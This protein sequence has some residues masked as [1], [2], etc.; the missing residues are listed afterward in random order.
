MNKS[1]KEL[2]DYLKN[3][4]LVEHIT[5][6]DLVSPEISEK[7]VQNYHRSKMFINIIPTNIELI[8]HHIDNVTES[9]E[10]YLFTRV[11]SQMI[12]WFLFTCRSI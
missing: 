4:S 5:F 9:L 10:L 11:S 8:P 3:K 1:K 12:K 7:L 6:F 2:K